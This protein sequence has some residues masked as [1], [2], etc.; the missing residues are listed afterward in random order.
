MI[1][2]LLGC[3]V[4]GGTVFL[5]AGRAE[6]SRGLGTAQACLRVSAFW[7]LTLLLT[8]PLG[9]WAWFGLGLTWSGACLLAGIGFA[10][11]SP[12]EPLPPAHEPDGIGITPN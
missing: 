8:A 1:A 2:F 7:L 6:L 3:L 12:P 4:S 11:L 5:L 9:A 10:V